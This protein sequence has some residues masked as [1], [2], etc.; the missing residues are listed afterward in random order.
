[1]ASDVKKQVNR[2]YLEKSQPSESAGL[3]CDE[4]SGE[5]QNG[6]LRLGTAILDSN[7]K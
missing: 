4:T 3:Q 7:S 1:M 2:F 5:N 6:P